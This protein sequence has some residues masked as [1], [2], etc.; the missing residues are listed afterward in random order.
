M[1]FLSLFLFLFFFFSSFHRTQQNRETRGEVTQSKKISRSGRWAVASPPLGSH[2]HRQQQQQED[3]EEEEQGE[4][5][6]EEEQEEEEEE[7]E[8]EEEEEKAWSMETQAD[9]VS[10]GESG[11]AILADIVKI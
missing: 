2:C 7:E 6:E 3:E 11:A 9:R 10:Q 8:Q 1:I 5:E 4:E